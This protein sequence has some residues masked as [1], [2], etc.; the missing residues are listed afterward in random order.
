MTAYAIGQTALEDSSQ[1]GRALGERLRSQGAAP[2]DV[3]LVFAAPS[4]DH[5]RFLAALQQACQPRLLLGC[6]SAGELSSGMAGEGMA[7]ALALCSEQMQF[8]V[9]IGQDLQAHRTQAA[10]QVVRSFQGVHPLPVRHR[11]ALLFADALAGQMDLLMEDL[12]RLTGGTYQFVGG[13][14]G[15]N[16][17][18]RSTPVFYGTEVLHDAV[19]ALEILS[20]LPLGIG[21]QHGWVPASA[22]LRVT[23]TDGPRLL[24]L[25]A[26]PAV[27]AWQASAEESGQSFDLNDPL[28]FFLHTI[29]GI[30]TPDGYRLRV[31]LSV[32]ANGA[33]LCAAEIPV[34]ATVHLMRTTHR[35]AAEAAATAATA[36]LAA[37]QGAEPAVALFFDCVATRLRMGTAFGGELDALQGVLGTT[38]Y[39]GCNTHGQFARAAGQFSGFHNCTA[40]VCLLP[41]GRSHV[42]DH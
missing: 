4:Y 3:V 17:R 20:P 18:F 12:T 5:T 1:A 22:P 13:G 9:G 11:T 14:A 33:V 10:E 6:S 7:C 34:G 26:M 28:P 35:S 21:V 27:E 32:E 31:P 38:P 37:L 39:V 15:D 41:E 25:N 42:L 29:I 36:A 19:V 2:A 16:A 8:A 30:A 40:V 24:S 23:Q